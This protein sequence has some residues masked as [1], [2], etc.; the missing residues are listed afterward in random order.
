MKDI[1]E[2]SNFIEFTDD[3]LD[4]SK[5]FADEKIVEFLEK[6]VFVGCDVAEKCNSEAKTN[7]KTTGFL[8]TADLVINNGKYSKENLG[9]AA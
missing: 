2:E 3:M 7:Q 4:F 8:D 1:F 5:M 9:E 6:N